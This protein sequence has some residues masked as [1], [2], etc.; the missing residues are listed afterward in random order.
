MEMQRNPRPSKDLIRDGKIVRMPHPISQLQQEYFITLGQCIRQVF[1]GDHRFEAFAPLERF[2]SSYEPLLSNFAYF[3]MVR[4][5]EVAKHPAPVQ[6]YRHRLHTV[7]FTESS[8][9]SV[10]PVIAA[11]EQLT[12][13]PEL[14]SSDAERFDHLNSMIQKLIERWEART[15][16]EPKS[17]QRVENDVEQSVRAVN[18]ALDRMADWT[19]AVDM[20]RDDFLRRRRF[21]NA[22]LITPLKQYREQVLAY[23]LRTEK[24]TETDSDTETPDDRPLVI[25]PESDLSSN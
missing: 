1:E 14:L 9:A 17:A 4:L 11:L 6:E 8:D 23:R 2:T 25:T 12:E 10:R 21:I 20:S 13:H 5:H 18:R 22:A 7:F 3:E 19:A 15:A 16:W 24:P